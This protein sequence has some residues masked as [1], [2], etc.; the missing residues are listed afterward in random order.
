MAASGEYLVNGEDV[1]VVWERL[2]KPENKLTRLSVIIEDYASSKSML[3]P[4]RKKFA[5][6]LEK[7]VLAKIKQKGDPR[8]NI[9]EGGLSLFGFHKQPKDSQGDVI[10]PNKDL[11]RDLDTIY[12]SLFGNRGIGKTSLLRCYKEGTFTDKYTSEID[13]YYL[14]PEQRF[15]ENDVSITSRLMVYDAYDAPREKIRETF[16]HSESH[17][18]MVVDITDPES[19]ENMKKLFEEFKK[20]LDGKSGKKV[21]MIAVTKCEKSN[22]DNDKGLLEEIK[23][24]AAQ[25]GLHVSTSS[26]K[27]NTGVQ[28]V[29]EEFMHEVIKNHYPSEFNF[30]RVGHNIKR[31][32]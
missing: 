16:Y 19:F 13:Y 1:K 17:Y 22:L 2:K 20:T 10:S 3:E 18:I 14:G 26:A 6:E 27:E 25:N 29:F 31:A 15:E 23:E 4:E 5:R 24:Y 9:L 8:E 30:E 28:E 32:R 7:Q 21:V 11:N 12:V